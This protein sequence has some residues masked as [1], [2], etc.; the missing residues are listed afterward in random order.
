VGKVEA[1]R[2]IGTYRWIINNWFNGQMYMQRRHCRSVVQT[3][4]H[5][6]ENNIVRH[7]DSIRHGAAKRGREI[8]VPARRADYYRPHGD[9]DTEYHRNNRHNLTP[10]AP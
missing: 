7:R 3:L 1:A 5:L 2:L 10:S 6:Q 9:I 4:L 8:K